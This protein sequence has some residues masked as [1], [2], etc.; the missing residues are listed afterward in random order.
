MSGSLL[1][2]ASLL[3]L[4][5]CLISSCAGHCRIGSRLRVAT[6]AHIVCCS[7]CYCTMD[8]PVFGFGANSTSSGGFRSGCPPHCIVDQ[9]VRCPQLGWSRQPASASASASA[10]PAIGRVLPPRAPSFVRLWSCHDVTCQHTQAQRRHIHTT[11]SAAAR[12][13]THTR[14]YS[15]K[16]RRV[17]KHSDTATVT[18]TR[19]DWKG[20]KFQSKHMQPDKCGNKTP[21]S[22]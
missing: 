15:Q 16:E 10:S 12:V 1:A 4:L 7:C 5:L 21:I 13:E 20:S 22:T 14:L 2:S 19:T 6:R 18:V 8:R 3:W 17:R 11:H 9:P